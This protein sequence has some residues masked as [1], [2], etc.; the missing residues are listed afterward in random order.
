MNLTAP[1][2][3]I[4]IVSDLDR[5]LEFYTGIL[6]LKLGHRS[7]EYAQLNTGRTRVALYTRSAMEKTLRIS[8]EAPAAN[9]PG[10]ELGFKV[11][12]VDS[13]YKQVIA[14]GAEAAIAPTDRFWGQRTAYVRDPDGYLIEL[15]QDLCGNQLR[16]TK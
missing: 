14:S 11:A 4:L 7:G 8:L 1:D 3:V 15:A 13:A 6:G 12:D 16:S 9:A 10:F 5:S 2:Y